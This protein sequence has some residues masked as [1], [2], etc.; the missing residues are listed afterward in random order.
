MIIADTRF[1]KIYTKTD[2]DG[3][4]IVELRNM[5]KSH[6][7]YPELTS[8]ISHL[9]HDEFLFCSIT[10]EIKHRISLFVQSIIDEHMYKYPKMFKIKWSTVIKNMLLNLLELSN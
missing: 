4:L 6:E 8:K 9:I 1:L 7:S 5:D 3:S 10:D 2:N